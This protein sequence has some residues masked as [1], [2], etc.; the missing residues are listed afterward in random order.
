MIKKIYVSTIVLAIASVCFTTSMN[1][2]TDN[3]YLEIAR[4]VLK[5]EKKAAFGIF[6]TNTRE[7][8]TPYKINA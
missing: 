4:D 7:N 1:A 5:V 8:C 6:T 2:Q 3:D